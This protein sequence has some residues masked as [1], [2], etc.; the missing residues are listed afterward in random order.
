MVAFLH[1][2]PSGPNEVVLVYREPVGADKK[3]YTNIIF[4]DYDEYYY[5]KTTATHQFGFG[6]KSLSFPTRGSMESDLEHYISWASQNLGRAAYAHGWFGEPGKRPRSVKP[7]PW[8]TPSSEQPK[9]RSVAAFS[10]LSGRVSVS[11]ASDPEDW[12]A[13]KLDMALPLGSHVQTGIDSMAL[14][15][16]P[17]GSS[18]VLKPESEIILTEEEK[19]KL[20]ILLVLGSIWMDVFEMVKY[21]R[22]EVEQSQA[23]TGP[24]G[25]V[26]V[27]EES[28]ECSVVKLLEDGPV[29]VT[30]KATGQMVTLH[31]GDMIRFFADGKIERGHVDVNNEM[32]TWTS[33]PVGRNLK[34]A[35]QSGEA[36][37]HPSKSADLS[38]GLI[39]S[40]DLVNLELRSIGVQGAPSQSVEHEFILPGPGRIRITH[41]VDPII[42][43]ALL[44]SPLYW[45]MPGPTMGSWSAALGHRTLEVRREPDPPVIGKPR[46][47]IA[48]V[49]VDARVEGLIARLSAPF[50]NTIGSPQSE[51]KQFAA[52]QSLKIEFVPDGNDRVSFPDLVFKTSGSYSTVFFDA[53]GAAPPPP[54]DLSGVWTESA[55]SW[56]LTPAGD[57]NYTVLE[58]GTSAFNGR[59]GDLSE[60]RATAEIKVERVV[61]KQ[62]KGAWVHKLIV[63]TEK[64]TEGRNSWFWKYDMTVSEDGRTATGGCR[65]NDGAYSAHTWTR[66]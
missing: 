59:P 64:K 38:P 52:Y 36:R 26:F 16:F 53:P 30:I 7:T 39:S 34:L 65:R 46:L 21:G 44:W 60:L 66:K 23:I 57:G 51:G 61:D 40:K 35:S 2:L 56:T 11:P 54:M 1:E 43:G 24:K 20:T 33:L 15:S 19:P 9:I 8:P 48:L 10:D 31:A 62:Q 37:K 6:G 17:D 42:E 13:A 58:K 4:L 32:A 14:I 45:G 50:Y 49:Q 29:E 5:G 47:I 28:A 12:R 22:M 3:V 41:Y 25:T 63:T 18:L 27:C 55:A